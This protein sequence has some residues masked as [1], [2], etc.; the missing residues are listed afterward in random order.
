MKKE[1][2]GIMGR[3]EVTLRD[4]D[5]NVKMHE[6]SKNLIV[7][8]GLNYIRDLIIGAGLP[9]TYMGIAWQN[10]GDP[11]NPVAGD[12]NFPSSITGQDRIATTPATNGNASWKMTQQWGSGEPASYYAA[13]PGTPCPIKGIGAFM[14]GGTGDTAFSWVK[15]PVINKDTTDVLEI[16]YIFTMTAVP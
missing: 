2:V 16:N 7:T 5:G 4:K 11:S 13:Y 14:G 1:A 9:M 10:S 3:V 8:Q 6:V 15:K 12:R